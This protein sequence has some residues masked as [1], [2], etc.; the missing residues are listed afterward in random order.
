MKS[1]RI[2]ASLCSFFGLLIAL[3]AAVRAMHD[4]KIQI[5]LLGD[6][7][8][9]GSIPRKIVPQ[10]PHLE[11]VIEQLLAAEADLPPAQVTNLGLSGEYIRRLLDTGRYDKVAA[12]LPGVDYIFIRYGPND[13]NRREN[14]DLNYPKDFRE[15]IARLRRDHP[16][17]M[18]IPT[19]AIPLNADL[20][21]DAPKAK[22]MN[23]LVY[24]VAAEE[25]LTLFNLYPRYASEQAKGPNM[26]NYR[27]YALA[28]IPEK[29]HAFVQPFV[30]PGKD[31]QVVVLDNRLDA[32]F[33]QLP[34]WF[35][36]RHPNLAGYHV[37]GDETAKFLAPLIR[38]K[39]GAAKRS[40]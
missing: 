21:V 2:L 14:F 31:A 15:L 7:T 10:G 3:P 26:L 9:E 37:I 34:G 28:K 25:K 5:V 8:T 40:P 16:A 17:A 22:R 23:D 18:L 39:F 4:G 38:A 11:Q 6:S 29:F 24:Q 36:D 13:V 20:A 12:R 33:G 35:D 32:H 30:I 1:R 19:T 27:R